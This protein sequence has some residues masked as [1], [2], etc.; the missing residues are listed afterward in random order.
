MSHQRFLA[1]ISAHPG[2]DAPKL[3]YA[4]WLEER[5][6][7]RADFIRLIVEGIGGRDATD[8]EI[9]A[10]AEMQW[11]T[12]DYETI[13]QSGLPRELRRSFAAD[14]AERALPNFQQ[15]LPNDDRPRRAIETARNNDQIASRKTYRDA[16]SAVE[17]ASR[18]VNVL[19]QEAN[20]ANEEKQ[21]AKEAEAEIRNA[22]GEKGLRAREETEQER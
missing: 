16:L 18:A 11:T 15:A 19:W 3:V 14:C 22:L 2:D 4:D 13:K 20:Q 17:A 8:K 9:V 12:T 7:K 1:D 21:A 5:G 10:A 6:D